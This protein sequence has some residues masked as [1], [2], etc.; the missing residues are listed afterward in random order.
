MVSWHFN[1]A[2]LELIE[3]TFVPAFQEENPNTPSSS[4]PAT[5]HASTTSC[6]AP[7]RPV[8]GRTCGSTAPPHRVQAGRRP[9]RRLHSTITGPIMRKDDYL[10]NVVETAYLNGK[11]YSVPRKI[12]LY[13]IFYRKDFFEEAGIGWAPADSLG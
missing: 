12:S 11:L 3:G 13:T 1:E 6:S 9:A 4:S 7:A 5:M 8:R 2:L 10:P